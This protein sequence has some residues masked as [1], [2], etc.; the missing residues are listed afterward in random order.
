MLKKIEMEEGFCI[1]QYRYKGIIC[2]N[3][4]FWDTNW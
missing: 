3:W 4:R 1:L 2:R